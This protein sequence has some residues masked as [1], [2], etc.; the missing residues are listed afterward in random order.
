[1]CQCGERVAG[2][3]SDDFGFKL[4]LSLALA[5]AAHTGITMASTAAE[6]EQFDLPTPVKQYEFPNLQHDFPTLT[7]TLLLQ[8]ATNAQPLALDHPPIWVMRQ[9]GEHTLLPLR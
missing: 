4:T 2:V 1:M 7:N 9:A 5:L 6:Q 8:S 3:A